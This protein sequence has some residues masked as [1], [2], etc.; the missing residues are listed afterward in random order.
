M[1]L[2]VVLP[3]AS[4]ACSSVTFYQIA[5]VLL[6]P[7]TAALNYVIL[8]TTLPRS[9]A[10]ALVPVCLGVAVVS[11]YDTAKASPGKATAPLG[12]IFAFTGVL[13]SA[14]Y[15]VWIAKYH[16]TLK[17]SS[18][19]LL[20]NQAPLSA[21]LLLYVIPFVDDITIWRQSLGSMW[22]SIVLV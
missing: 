4:L 12:V 3:N 13:M 9:A 18:M 16:K 17:L 7:C 10:L 8:G 21:F 15:T 20:L 5:R 6:T 22:I 11:Y 19:Q 2:N 14:V 1:I